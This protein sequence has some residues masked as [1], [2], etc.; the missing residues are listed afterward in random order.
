MLFCTA[1]N[2]SVR[3]RFSYEHPIAKATYNKNKKNWKIFWQRADLKWHDYE[4]HLEAAS[5]EEF[6]N[7]VEKDDHGCFFG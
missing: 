6:L 3:W 5:I 1:L 4:P 7:V 2:L